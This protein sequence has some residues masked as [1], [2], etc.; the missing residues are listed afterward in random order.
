M[1]PII[2]AAAL[3]LGACGLTPQGDFIREAIKAG[4]E[5]A[6]RQ[7]LINMEWGLCWGTPIGAIKERYGGGKA[8]AYNELCD[9]NG[10]G[11][12]K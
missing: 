1:K 6:A 8:G 10:G 5:N 3:F 11:I 9:R 12:V 7:G 2:I 4:T